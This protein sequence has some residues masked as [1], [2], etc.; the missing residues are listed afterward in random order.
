MCCMYGENLSMFLSFLRA[1]VFKSRFVVLSAS[2]FFIGNTS[3]LSLSCLQNGDKKSL[4]EN[5]ACPTA[6]LAS[7]SSLTY[8]SQS[9]RYTFTNLVA[10][11]SLI[12]TGSDFPNKKTCFASNLHA[13][14]WGISIVLNVLPSTNSTSAN[15]GLYLGSVLKGISLH[16][17]SVIMRGFS[18]FLK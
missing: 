3:D 15:T 13:C 18:F 10:K 7:E 5:Y 6:N 16:A 8:S 14:Y 12:K 2:Y 9:C 4:N 11:Y 1:V 17:I